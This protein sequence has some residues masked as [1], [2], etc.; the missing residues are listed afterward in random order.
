MGS[1]DLGSTAFEFIADRP[2]ARRWILVNLFERLAAALLLTIV[3]PILFIASVMVVLIS[4]R[5]PFIAHQRVGHR[6]RLIWVL[7]L[8]TMWQN[9]SGKRLMFVHRLTPSEAPVPPPEQKDMGVTSRFA[10]C[11]R[12][13]SLDELPQLW[14]VVRGEM[15][16]IGPRPLTREELDVYYGRDAATVILHRPGISGLWQVKGR[17]RL[18]YSQRRR[19]DMFL[20]R[21]WSLSLYFRILFLT[22]PSVLAGKNAR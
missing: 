15:S 8:R 2:Y 21:K 7:K 10:A 19:L 16:L 20:I 3:L 4:R 6:G 18:T 12:R 13:L 14:Q 22:V 17:S 5:S 11:C 1:I 9:H